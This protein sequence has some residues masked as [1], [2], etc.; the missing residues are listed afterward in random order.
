MVDQAK[1][2]QRK[3]EHFT[4]CGICRS[5]AHNGHV[6]IT[7]TLKPENFQWNLNFAITLM[8]NSLNLN[9]AYDYVF[10]N[11]S[12]LAYIIEIQKIQNLLKFISMNL[13]NLSQV[14]KLHS[15]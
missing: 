3:R 13:T 14:T 15:L 10:R 1:G 7:H 11:L 8:A 4:W 2:H 6:W 12:M 5:C 9:C